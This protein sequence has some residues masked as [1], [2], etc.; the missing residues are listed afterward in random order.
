MHN[1]SHYLPIDP[2]IKIKGVFTEDCK[3]FDSNTH[4]IKYTFKI[5]QDTKKIFTFRR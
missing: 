1:E 2:K 4:P 3:V 5:T